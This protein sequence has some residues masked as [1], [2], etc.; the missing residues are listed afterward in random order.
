MNISEL[1]L[2]EQDIIEGCDVLPET[3][4][5]QFQIAA[6]CWLPD[7]VPNWSHHEVAATPTHHCYRFATTLCY[8]LCTHYAAHRLKFGI[9]IT[10][11]T[12]VTQNIKKWRIWNEVYMDLII[13]LE[14][15]A[16]SN[17]SSDKN[18]CACGVEWF[19]PLWD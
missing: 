3:H 11:Y 14:H 17:C 16:P 19:F 9:V 18:C 8:T 1:F 10:F 12:K 15:V 4:L 2:P 7:N 5:I 13:C 6:S